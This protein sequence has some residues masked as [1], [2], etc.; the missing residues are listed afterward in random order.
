MQPSDFKVAVDIMTHGRQAIA[1]ESF[2]QLKNE[3]S[4]RV[5]TGYLEKLWTLMPCMHLVCLPRFRFETSSC[6]L[7]PLLAL[8]FLASRFIYAAS[9]PTIQR[10]P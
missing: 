2:I 3:A 1:L 9:K 8:R 5:T 10:F 7:A 6:Q 4:L